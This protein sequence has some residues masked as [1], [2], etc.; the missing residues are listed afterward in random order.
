MNQPDYRTLEQRL[1][2]LA[3]A[4]RR[5]TYLVSGVF[6]V[7]AAGA[8]WLLPGQDFHRRNEARDRYECSREVRMMRYGRTHSEFVPLWQ[9][10]MTAR[11]YEGHKLTL[12]EDP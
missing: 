6:L 2:R 9:S 12:I 7:L 8:V 10:C 1:D 11:G 4:V 5:L 3:R